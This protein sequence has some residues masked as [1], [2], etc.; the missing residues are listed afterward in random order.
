MGIEFKCFSISKSDI[1]QAIS[2]EDATADVSFSEKWNE[3]VRPVIVHC[4]PKDIF[5]M[6][7]TPL[8]CSAELKRTLAVKEEMF[9]GGK[10]YKNKGT[11]L[12]CIM[13]V[14]LKN[15]VL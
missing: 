11:I 10:G 4:S 6:D 7:K 1:W 5:N 12:L 9:Q 8:F 2:R 14:T 3:N 13:E 15:C